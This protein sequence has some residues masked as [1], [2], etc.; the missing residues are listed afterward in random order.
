MRRRRAS[1]L[2]SHSTMAS[3]ARDRAMG[4]SKQACELVSQWRLVLWHSCTSS[5]R[6]ALWVYSIG[7]DRMCLY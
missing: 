6:Q 5:F 4:G 1:R 3:N 2:A 7:L